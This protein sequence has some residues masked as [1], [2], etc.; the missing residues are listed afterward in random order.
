MFDAVLSLQPRRAPRPGRVPRRRA[1][2]TAGSSPPPR[3]APD[4][5]RL[6][7][8][9]AVLRPRLAG[10]LEAVGRGRL[11]WTCR[12]FRDPR[13]L[14]HPDVVYG[15]LASV[16]AERTTAEWIESVPGD[17]RARRAGADVGRDRRRS[18]RHMRRGARRRA[19]RRRAATVR[20][21][22]PIIFDDTP[23][24]V[25]RPA[26]LVGQH[27]V[28][29]LD[30]VGFTADEIAAL[31]TTEHRPPRP[32]GA[33]C[34]ALT[35]TSRSATTTSPSSSSAAPEQLLRPGHD[36]RDRRRARGAE[37]QP[38]RP[39]R[40]RC[41]RAASTS[42]PEPTS[43]AARRPRLRPER[44]RR[45]PPLRR[46]SADLRP[47]AADR[48]RR[49]GC[50]DRRWPRR[51]ARPPICAWPRPRRASPPRSPGSACTTASG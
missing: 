51:R 24:S 20:S 34:P 8:C 19:P 41:A 5:R 11:N 22:R 15:S 10:A 39:R 32:G 33:R 3:P 7:R 42:A 50:G 28:E 49:A 48:R 14:E 6:R 12:C 25:R 18:E 38:R 21:R 46:R 1:P 13:R 43:P 40:C 27:T 30:E 26:P 4:A 35:S 2:A 9:A 16:I 31:L 45:R 37:R 29:L 23:M 44:Q 47:A 17:R 36:L